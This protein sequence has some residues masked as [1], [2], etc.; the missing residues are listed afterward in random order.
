M[1][2]QGAGSVCARSATSCAGPP[3]FPDVQLPGNRQQAGLPQGP[4][5]IGGQPD[6]SGNAPPFIT[7]AAVALNSLSSFRDPQA[8][9][10]GVSP[11]RTRSST[12]RLQSSQRYSNSGMVRG[13]RI[14]DSTRWVSERN[15]SFIPTTQTYPDVGQK[16]RRFCSPKR[17]PETSAPGATRR[18]TPSPTSPQPPVAPPTRPAVPD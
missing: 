4:A 14:E 9:Q 1:P 7:G 6:A 12:S 17:E 16:G 13:I 8:G 11:L 3:R 15:D 18:A 5:S 10:T 2:P